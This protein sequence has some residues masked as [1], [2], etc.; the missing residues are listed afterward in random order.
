MTMG[1]RPTVFVTFAVSGGTPI[2]SRTGNVMIEAPPA[3]ALA[4]PAARPAAARASAW[5]SV[6]PGPEVERVLGAV[7]ADAVRDL[8]DPAAVLVDV[9]S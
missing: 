3:I 6:T 1:E 4:V 7:A 5:S 9:A 8:G 2:A